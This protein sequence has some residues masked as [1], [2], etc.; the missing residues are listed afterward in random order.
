[1]EGC[2]TT[3]YR[4]FDEGLGD[5]IFCIYPPYILCLW[6]LGAFL[7]LWETFILGGDEGGTRSL[8]RNK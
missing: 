8:H 2:S 7:S 4:Y 3:L 1:M 5:T 6:I